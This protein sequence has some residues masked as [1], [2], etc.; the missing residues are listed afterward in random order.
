[1]KKTSEKKST[2]IGELETALIARA[3]ALADEHMAHARRARDQIIADAN[4]RQR[5]R[6]EREILAAKAVAERAFRQRQQAAEIKQQEEVDRLRWNLVATVMAHLPAELEKL[7]TDEKIYHSL[8]RKLL[9]QAASAV[10]TQELVA[11]V[12]ARDHARLSK[13]W[14]AFCREAGIKNP[15]ALAPESILCSGGVRLRNAAD[16]I[17]VDNSFE[18]RLERLQDGLYQIIMQRLFAATASIGA[19]IDG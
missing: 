2:P 4:E 1:M 12:N 8:M 7:I 16:T 10:A 9:A 19:M 13:T 11:E 18:G 17:R 6:E 14:E 15:I 3:K 5:L